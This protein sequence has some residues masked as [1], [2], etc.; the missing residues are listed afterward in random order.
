MQEN[1]DLSARRPNPQTRR[2][3]LR[4]TWLQIL[5]PILAA[6]LIFIALAVLVGL[7]PNLQVSR[8]SNISLILLIIPTFLVGMIFLAIMA[9]GIYAISRLLNAI[10]PYAH[11]AQMYIEAFGRAIKRAAD[12]SASPVISVESIAA[13]IGAVF[14]RGPARQ[15]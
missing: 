3:H 10:P 13:S 8:Y 5:L 9:G 14:K 12:L 15:Q 4:Q 7:A 6:V 11:L 1:F 2:L